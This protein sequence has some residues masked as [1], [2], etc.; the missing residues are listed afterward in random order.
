[1]LGLLDLFVIASVVPGVCV[2]WK[3]RRVEAGAR[4]RVLAGND[5]VYL[6]LPKGVKP[7]TEPVKRGLVTLFYKGKKGALTGRG[8]RGGQRGSCW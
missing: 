2:A 8:L 1:M 4:G 6:I 3:K 5:S 7:G